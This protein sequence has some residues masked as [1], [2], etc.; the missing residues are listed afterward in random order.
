MQVILA[1]KPDQA[2]KLS[3][4]FQGRK[5]KDHI[6]IEPCSLFP[7]G[8]I[9]VWAIGH[10]I[11]LKSPE[12]YKD[13]WKKWD[14][15]HLPIIPEGFQYKT[16]KD[17]VSHFKNIKGH[18]SQADEIVIATD[19][20]REGEYIAR[21]ILQLSGA[22]KKPIKRLWCSSL[23]E[24]AIQKAFRN[25]LDGEETKSLYFEALA[26]A[27]SDWL[28]G[29]NTSRLYT[30]LMR[31]KGVKEVFSAGRVQ[32]PLL[33]LIRNR[34]IEIEQFQSKPFWELEGI[35][36]TEEG[37]EY[38]GKYIEK[39]FEKEKAEAIL[40]DVQNHEG[41][42]SEIQTE[43]KAVKPPLLHSLSTLQ[44]KINRKY[45]IS[46][47]DV[48]VNV[49]TLYEKGYISY[50][51]SDSQHVPTA[52]A[53]TFPSILNALRKYFSIPSGVRNI[54]SDKRFVN[55]K[56][57]SDHYAIIPTEEIPSNLDD[58]SK[59]EKL[60]YDE[61]ARS[62]ISAHMADYRYE[63]TVIMT[64]VHNYDFKTI[65]NRIL[66]YG[67]KN[68]FRDEKESEKEEIA[69]LPALKIDQKVKSSI[70]LKEGITKPPKAYTEGQ[71]VTLMKTAGK[72]I[73][74]DDLQADMKG[75][76]LGTEATRSGIIQTLKNRNY[77]EVKKNVAYVTEK[78]KL[79]ASAVQGTVLAKPDLTARWEQYLYQIGQKKKEAQPFIER[80][81]ELVQN[82]IK[83]SIDSYQS[84]DVSSCKEI[85]SETYISHCPICKSGIV[86][87]K[88]FYGCTGY[89]N[90]CKFT[91]PKKL[92][93]KKLSEAIVKKLIEGKT[94]QLV[95]GFTSSKGKKFDAKLILKDGKISFIFS[96]NFK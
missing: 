54:L 51:R 3:A 94:T 87:R 95:K 76:G 79:L 8:A 50:P 81:K 34:E 83:E 46:P 19:P 78:G 17:K 31:E 77:I 9:V 75:M 7:K 66:D 23:T 65:G 64:N 39:F 56:K 59:S 30:L 26:R 40:L 42:V 49:Q 55:D 71:L 14:L 90:G 84:W 86:D 44:A 45:K 16:I 70:V 18:L 74:D 85:V 2:R 27:Q 22:S 60:I 80:S 68:M 43:E 72:Y 28:V 61:I 41:T 62:L 5:Q 47:S 52:E 57:V 21:L 91:L 53:E 10:L 48:L 36:R 11:E 4:P 63:Q 33:C 29:M 6:K 92:L 1:E 93:G 37:Q 96:D 73:D 35:F 20:A 24:S 69:L 25:L 67:W 15:K 58:L 32:T 88:T 82:L 12:E 13:N 38:Q 89:K